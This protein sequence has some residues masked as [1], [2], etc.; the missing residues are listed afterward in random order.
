MFL[1]AQVFL[2]SKSVVGEQ[3]R[4]DVYCHYDTESSVEYYSRFTNADQAKEAMV[5]AY[6]SN[7]MKEAVTQAKVLFF[8]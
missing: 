3:L 2:A 1:V 7:D 5:N 4:F 8:P 6:A